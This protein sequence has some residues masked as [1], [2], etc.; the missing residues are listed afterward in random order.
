[1]DSHIRL[2][3]HVEHVGL[4]GAFPISAGFFL[5][6]IRVRRRSDH[7]AKVAGNPSRIR[8]S[9]HMTVDAPRLLTLHPGVQ[10]HFHVGQH[11]HGMTA[12]TQ[13]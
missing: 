13:R 11:I 12:L 8:G 7:P 3:G 4:Q 5:L 6:C 9:R 2:Q 10:L 1:M